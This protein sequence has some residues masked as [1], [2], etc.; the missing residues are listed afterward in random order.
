MLS[1]VLCLLVIIVIVALIFDYVNGFHD[2]ANAIATVVSTRALTPRQGV[3]LAGAL[4]FIG[5][6]LSTHVAQT[7]GKGLV[8]VVQVTQVV[9]LS[10]LIGAII[11]NLLTWYFGLPSSS[12]HALIGG[13]VGAV[14]VHSGLAFVHWMD[15]VKKVLLPA[16][17]SPVIGLIVGFIFM[18]ILIWTFRKA[19]PF[20]VNNFFRKAQIVSASFMALS[21]GTNDAQKVMGIITL[22][23]LSAGAINVFE[24]P[25]WVKVA[26]ALA[27]ALGTSAGGWRIIRTL[28]AKTVKLKPI[29]GFAAET[30]ASIVLF[31][32][33]H[34]GFPVS[35]T[36]VITSSIMGAGATQRLSA[37]RW[38]VANTILMAWIFTLPASALMGGIAYA[39]L[40]FV[41]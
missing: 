1:G 37:V 7:V 28:G 26:C 14:I 2:S 29:Q 33:A 23:L 11:W 31:T 36:H 20:K 25:M 35:T 24:V 39:L 4:N 12:S 9:V 13:L 18:V 15:I 3:L 6:F 16:V 27:M 34:F 30:A 17:I 32:T 10:G 40:K 38:G 22:A 19:N 8:D 41:F 21:H 5:A